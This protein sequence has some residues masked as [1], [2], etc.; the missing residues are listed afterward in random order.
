MKKLIK[1][2]LAAAVI[3]AVVIIVAVVIV[4][5]RMTGQVNAFDRSNMN[6]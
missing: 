2:L 5:I 4:G 1:I 6:H 3:I